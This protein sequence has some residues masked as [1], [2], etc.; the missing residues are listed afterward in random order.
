MRGTRIVALLAGVT[1]V[2]AL[3]SAPVRAHCPLCSAG[4]GGAAAVAS[5]LGVGLAAVGVFVGAFGIATGLWTATY[6]D[7]QYVPQ[8]DRLLAVGVALSI[9]LPVLPIANETV[10]VF[11]SVA[12]E[13][14]SPLNRTYLFN[15]YLIGAIVGGVVTSSA[16]RV[17]GWL[18]EIRGSTVPFQGL[19]LTFLLLATSATALEVFL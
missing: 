12:G 3:F 17:S 11:V 5:A 6:V 9:V 15:A 19:A 14:G 18:S 2:P 16:P 10:P 8:Q 13:Y 1:V 4:A 7:R